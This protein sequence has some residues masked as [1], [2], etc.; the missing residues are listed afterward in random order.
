MSTQQGKSPTS[1]PVIAKKAAE[2]SGAQ[3]VD[4]FSGS[5]SLRDLRAP[6]RDR[7]EAFVAA[8]RAAGAAVTIAATYR[9]PKRAYLMHWSWRIIKR[10]HDPLTVPPMEGVN[11]N[12][13]HEDEDGKYSSQ[14]SFIAAKAMVDGFN[15]Q[16]L[17]VAPAL[18]SRH[19]L[20]FAVDM[21]VRW[22]GVLV[23]PDAYDNIIKI[24]T[25]P[26]SGL[27]LQLHRVGESYGVIKYNRAGRDD[28]HWSDIGA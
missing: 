23:I 2:F 13:A 28:P 24:Q 18:Q 12:W 11:I 26:R 25:F 3:W 17:G 5:T 1:L 14:S 10:K 19:T 21:N 6:F 7:A 9:P 16:N 22:T 27:N 8:L 15:I 4:R 20:G